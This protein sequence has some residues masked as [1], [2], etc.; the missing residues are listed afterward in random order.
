M[1]YVRVI[2]GKKNRENKKVDVWIKE[3]ERKKYS[4]PIKGKI[5]KRE[6]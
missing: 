5:R 1:D 6:N 2:K 3:F 4:Y